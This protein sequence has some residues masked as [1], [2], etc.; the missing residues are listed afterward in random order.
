MY[1]RMPAVAGSFYPADPENLQE[2]ILSYLKS[3]GPLSGEFN[4]NKIIGIISPH[5][6]YIYSGPVAAYGYNYLAKTD[7]ERFVVIAPSHHRR[8]NGVSVIPKGLYKTPLGDVEIDKDLGEKLQK[9]DY[10]GYVEEVHEVE[11]SLEVQIPFLQMV[12]PEAK[13]VPLVIG[14]VDL[15][16]CR[17][18]GEIIAEEIKLSGKDYGVIISTDLSHYHSYRE[19]VKMDNE[20]INA[21]EFFDEKSVKEIIAAGKC[22]ACGEGAVFAGI[23]LC[24]KLGAK[25]IKKIQYANSGDTAGSKDQVVGYLSAL[26]LG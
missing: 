25:K 26:I 19:A 21:L 1:I 10:F 23:T 8:F 20:F 7:L 5:A 22:E 13:I 11:H 15:D 4:D 6:G 9:K 2:L 3:A 24:R 12:K 14:T 16:I 18:I 17:I